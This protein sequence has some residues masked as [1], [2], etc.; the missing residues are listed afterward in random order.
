MN[1]VLDLRIL[2]LNFNTNFTKFIIITIY[3]Y[4]NIKNLF[5]KFY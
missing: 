4:V 3:A 1:E 2:I 5:F